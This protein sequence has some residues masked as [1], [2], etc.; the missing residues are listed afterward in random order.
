MP[1]TFIWLIKGRYQLAVTAN[2][3]FPAFFTEEVL[4]KKKKFLG[5]FSANS[6]SQR[7]DTKS[8]LPLDTETRLVQKGPEPFWAKLTH[9]HCVHRQKT[10]QISSAS[11]PLCL[12]FWLI[13]HRSGGPSLGV[14]EKWPSSFA[15]CYFLGENKYHRWSPWYCIKVVRPGV[16]SGSGHGIAYCS[17][18]CYPVP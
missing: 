10:W 12:S 8:H 9:F 1:A 5:P 2:Y 3:C 13:F 17:E 15:A 6:G 7:R 16:P 18:G 11:F 4:L 14:V